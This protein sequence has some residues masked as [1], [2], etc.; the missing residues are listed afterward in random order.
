VV[1]RAQQQQQQQ[2]QQQRQRQQQQHGRAGPPTVGIRAQLSLTLTGHSMPPFAGSA[3]GGVCGT[4]RPRSIAA[5][6]RASALYRQRGQRAGSVLIQS[7]SI[8]MIM[9]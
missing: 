7:A 1:R 2:Q 9:P 4:E 8:V 5:R 6:V 3:D